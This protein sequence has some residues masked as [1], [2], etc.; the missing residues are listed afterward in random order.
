MSTI[1][2]YTFNKKEELLHALTHGIGGLLSIF[3]LVLLIVF[4]AFTK[5]ALTIVSVTI[6]GVTMTFMYLSSTIVHSLTEGT[7]KNLFQI[8][9]HSSIFLF[10]AGS[11]TPFLLTQ[12]K[13]TLGWTLFGIV[14]GIALV[15]IILKVFFVEKFLILSTLIYILMGWLIVVAWGPLT[16]SLAPNGVRL[17]VIGGLFYTFGAVFYVVRKIPYHHVIWH[18][19]VILGSVAHF[20]SV[21][22]YVI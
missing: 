20:F 2:T 13:G 5:D 21:F 9:D 12:I 7:A 6:F 1:E 18:V 15:G 22:F 3:G 19:F 16:D 4:S 8:L 11:Y 14:W 17:L 10:I